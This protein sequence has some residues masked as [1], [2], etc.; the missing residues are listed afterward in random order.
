MSETSPWWVRANSHLLELAVGLGLLLVGLFKVLF[1]ILGVVGAPSATTDTRTV[2]IDTAAS[3]PDV[4]AA[5]PVTLRGTSQAEL[6]FHDPGFGDRL[7]LILPGLVSAVLLIVILEVLIRL[8]RTFHSA[9]FFAPQNSR[10]LLVI[11]G[12]IL[13]IATLPPALDVLTTNLLLD[14]TPL[15]RAVHTAYSINTVALFG[16]LLTA[17]AATA[18]RQGTR[19]RED[20]EGLV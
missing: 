15:Q 12:A 9:D 20:T 18:F 6:V 3:M 1:P 11:S 8:T 7:L 16:A 17:A 10:R 2:G 4:T 5:G 13:L 19:L 14:G